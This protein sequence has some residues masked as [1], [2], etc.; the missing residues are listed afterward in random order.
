MSLSEADGTNLP[1]FSEVVKMTSERWLVGIPLHKGPFCSVLLFPNDGRVH[2]D[3][4]R[5]E[6]EGTSDD[7]G[8]P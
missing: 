3:P 7:D 2:A 1:V 4:V 5:I 8:F 6:R